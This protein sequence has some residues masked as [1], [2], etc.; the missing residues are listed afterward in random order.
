[1]DK[2]HIPAEN[3]INIIKKPHGDAEIEVHTTDIVSDGYHTIGELY[4]HRITLYMAMCKIIMQNMLTNVWRSRK[5][6]DGEVWD[7]WF[8]LGIN[9][10]EGKQI[11][12]H[13]PETRWSET[14]FAMTLDKAPD[15]D[16]HT[17]EDVLNRI[18]DL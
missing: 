6:S 13:I 16:G 3:M 15:F 5:H 7:K 18:K 1:M 12:Y 4:D 2:I 9:T 14:D 8:I 17:S 10:E 11:T